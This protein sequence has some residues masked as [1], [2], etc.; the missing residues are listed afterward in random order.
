MVKETIQIF[1]RIKPTKKTV[2]VSGSQRQTGSVC[3]LDIFVKNKSYL[4]HVALSH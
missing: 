3:M 1:A 2:A 4:P